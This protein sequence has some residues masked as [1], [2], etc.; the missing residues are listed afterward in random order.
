MKLCYLH[1]GGSDYF[2]G[3]GLSYTVQVILVVVQ[4]V[5]VKGFFGVHVCYGW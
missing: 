5:L 4:G 3:S 1:G 2:Y